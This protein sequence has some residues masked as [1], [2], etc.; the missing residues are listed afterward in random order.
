MAGAGTASAEPVASAPGGVDAASGVQAVQSYRNQA[1]GECLNSS[2]NGFMWTYPCDGSSRRQ[3]NVI[4]HSDGTRGF[5]NIGNGYCLDD[6][7]EYNIRAITCTGV[8]YQRW[9]ITRWG[10]GTIRFQNRRT[11]ECLD[12]TSGSLNTTACNTSRGQSRHRPS[13]K[14]V[15][16]R[17][18]GHPRRSRQVHT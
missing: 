18:G 10:D 16:T 2:P 4:S 7:A 1:T 13:S 15:G 8:I 11:L 6:S 3:W 14:R 5:K 17:F 9:S 12:D